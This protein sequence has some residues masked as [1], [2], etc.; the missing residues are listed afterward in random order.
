[1]I[2]HRPYKRVFALSPRLTVLV[3]DSLPYTRKLTVE[4]S[5]IRP[6]CIMLGMY[7]L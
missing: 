3:L 4:Y 2:I 7:A 1:M 5:I 6:T